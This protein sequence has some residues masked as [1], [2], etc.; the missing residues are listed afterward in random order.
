[1]GADTGRETKHSYKQ[2]QPMHVADI[3]DSHG[4]RGRSERKSR[5]APPHIGVR[6]AHVRVLYDT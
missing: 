2:P 4:A 6:I 3:D 5:W 1:M